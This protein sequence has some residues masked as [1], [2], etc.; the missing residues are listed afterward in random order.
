MSDSPT[1]DLAIEARLRAYAGND[2]AEPRKVAVDEFLF[3]TS[4]TLDELPELLIEFREKYAHLTIELIDFEVNDE[5]LGEM[6]FN[7]GFAAVRMETPEE[8]MARVAKYARTMKDGETERRLHYEYV[9][10]LPADVGSERL[11]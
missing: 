1:L 8:V 9:E 3:T 4:D 11:H 2:Y 7:N 5:E 6:A 10:Q